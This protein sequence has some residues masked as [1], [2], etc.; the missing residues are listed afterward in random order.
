[1]T[2]KPQHTPEVPEGYRLTE[3]DAGPLGTMWTA[4]GPSGDLGSCGGGSS[5]KANA[6]RA[7]AMCFEDYGRRVHRTCAGLD[8]AAL[9]ALIEAAEAALAHCSNAGYGLARFNT[10]GDAPAPTIT[11]ELMIREATGAL[12]Y[13]MQS[14]RGKGG[15]ND[16]ASGNEAVGEA[17]RR[18]QATSDAAPAALPN[19]VR[20]HG[21]PRDFQAA[22]PLAS[23]IQAAQRALEYFEER[24][25]VDY[26][27]KTERAAGNAE[28][29]EAEALRAALASVRGSK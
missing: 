14:V 27:D 8:P 10:E 15:E 2:A 13:A 7:A 1:M 5:G 16:A 6:R 9:P 4:Y 20:Q 26:S 12:R 24:E 21:T 3:S 28:Y 11:A 17:E 19:S 18:E 25:S 29:F 22:T 23:L